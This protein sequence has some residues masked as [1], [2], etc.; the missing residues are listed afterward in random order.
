M[1]ILMESIK[2]EDF[3]AI[4]ALLQNPEAQISNR[5]I[6]AMKK[7]WLNEQFAPELLDYQKQ[8]IEDLLQL[9][10]NQVA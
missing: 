5:D 9:I 7:A 2:D 4:D 8:V 6:D 1:L 3:D 10:E